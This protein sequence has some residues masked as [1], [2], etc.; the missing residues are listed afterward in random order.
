MANLTV[1]L[2]GQVVASLQLETGRTYIAGRAADADIPLNPERGI[3]RHH[4]KFFEQDGSWVC[5]TLSKFVRI[6]KGGESVDV[7]DLHSSTIFVMSSYEFYFEPGGARAASEVEA[8]SSAQVFVVPFLRILFP[9]SSDEEIH[10]LEGH[11]WTVGRDQDCEI[12]I[13]SSHVSRRHFDLTRADDGFYISDLGSSNGTY[14]NGDRL[15]AYAATKL[16]PGDAIEIKSIRMFLEIRD[17]QF[18]QKISGF[19]PIH[20]LPP[21]EMETVQVKIPGKTIT[22]TP[23]RN[24]LSHAF[25]KP[26]VIG[27]VAMGV[28]ASWLKRGPTIESQPPAGTLTAEKQAL[29]KTSFE[30]ARNLY[31]RGA[32]ANCAAELAKMH[33][34][35]PKYEN[36]KELAA[37]CDKGVEI[38]ADQVRLAAI[39][40]SQ[41]A[42]EEFIASN[43]ENCKT[44]LG[45]NASVAETK[46][47]L[48]PAMDFHSG[49]PLIAEMLDAAALHEKEEKF[50][51]DQK[52][53]ELRKKRLDEAQRALASVQKVKQE[54]AAALAKECRTLGAKKD[55]KRAY[56][57]C[58][59]A[60]NLDPKNKEAKTTA[61]KVLT[62]FNRKLKS[63][64]ED[65]VIE[66]SMGNVAQAKE[67]WQKIIDDDLE[68]GK[69]GTM[70]REK[71]QKYGE[72][73]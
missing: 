17:S 25:F 53:A 34:L 62:S 55:Y 66:E 59:E 23:R 12:T 6:E 5:E 52:V 22:A 32:Y 46:D 63:L 45:P 18:S 13:D 37:F 65:S 67:K 50:L 26:T 56:T 27:L 71:L 29:V 15:T 1:K 21:S 19:A 42:A 31:I 58:R 7:V 11:I 64:Y 16:S 4:L 60:L 30:L 70:A 36:S 49:H 40:A 35:V 3:S 47:C 14:L 43:V 69:Y 8:T 28:L 72:D 2:R 38:H 68:N 54:K 33:E 61:E 44:K 10:R 24:L 20:P 48:Q 41:R 73:N 57:L 9:N 39:E 51:N